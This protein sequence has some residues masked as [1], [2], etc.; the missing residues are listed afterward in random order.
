MGEPW[1]GQSQ[2]RGT[3]DTFAGDL[4]EPTRGFWS[5]NFSFGVNILNPITS[6]PS[7]LKKCFSGWS[8]RPGDRNWLS[9]KQGSVR[10]QIP[11]QL[12]SSPSP[13]TPLLLP[14]SF[15]EKRN[16][17]TN[18]SYLAPNQKGG[19]AWKSHLLFLSLLLY[20]LTR[21]INL[22]AEMETDNINETVVVRSKV[23][24]FSTFD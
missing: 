6:F 22:H 4:P 7:P 13:C 14:L 19:G 9:Q 5:T 12:V 2:K 8:D 10:L 18:S 20:R 24:D 1:S 17:R 23:T 21:V 11:S 3:E 16:P 15:Q